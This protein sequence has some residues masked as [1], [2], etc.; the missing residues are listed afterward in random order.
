MLSGLLGCFLAAIVGTTSLLL[1]HIQVIGTH[2]SYHVRPPAYMIEA[3]LSVSDDARAWDYTH[4]PLD[5][6]LTNGVYNFELDIHPFVGGFRVMHVPIIDEETTCP[7]IA[8]C[9]AT[10]MAWSEAHPG[11][12]PISFLFEFKLTEALLAGEPLLPADAAMLE[13]FEQQ[14]LSVVPREKILTP[15]DV[16]GDG[17]TLAAAVQERGWPTLESSLG[18]VFFVLHN[19]T[20]LRDAYTENR[21]SLEGRIMF[22]NSSPGRDD[23]A[24]MVVDN[25]YAERIPEYIAAGMIIR[26]RSDSGLRQGRTGDT[27]RRDAAFASGAHIISTDFPRG[28]AHEDTG[29]VVEFPGGAP[30]RCNPLNSPRDCEQQLRALLGS[31]ADTP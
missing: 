4:D 2:N 23:A 26:V 19:R 22:V 6:Q 13:Q 14:I 31:A 7:E 12:I 27:S 10:V 20:E 30:A 16:R 9:L 5:V 21:P 28:R 25:P 8:D 15:D 24:V 29:Y 11:H 3:A 17:A 1:N 18:K